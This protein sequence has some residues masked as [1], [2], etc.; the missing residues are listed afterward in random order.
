MPRQ[1]RVGFVFEGLGNGVLKQALLET[2]AKIAGKDP[3]Q[4]AG[5]RRGHLL[6]DG[7]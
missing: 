2:D 4:V 6:E 1:E 3:D 5:R 7:R